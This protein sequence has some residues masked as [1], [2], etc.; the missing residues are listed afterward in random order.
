VSDLPFSKTTPVTE[1]NTKIKEFIE[2]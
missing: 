2:P 1:K